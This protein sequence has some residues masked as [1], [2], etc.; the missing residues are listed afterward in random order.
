MKVECFVTV[1]E[2]WAFKTTDGKTTVV[3]RAE[4]S[5]HA[6]VS[7]THAVVH[8]EHTLTVRL[9]DGFA[10]KCRT[11]DVVGLIKGQTCSFI[12]EYNDKMNPL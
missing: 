4:P 2:V 1:N 6:A 12:D 11:C 7:T 9:S 5:D 3:G 10:E 8:Q